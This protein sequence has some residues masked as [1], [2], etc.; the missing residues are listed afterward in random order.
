MSNDSHGKK[1]EPKLRELHNKLSSLGIN[2]DLFKIIHRPGWTTL[3]ELFF[4]ENLI[5]QIEGTHALLVSQ[6]NTLY[7]GSKLIE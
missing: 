3:A 7:E 5:S 4:A 2:Q 1:L 6:L